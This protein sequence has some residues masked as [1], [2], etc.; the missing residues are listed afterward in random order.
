VQ[1]VSNPSLPGGCSFDAATFQGVFNEMSSTSGH[2]GQVQVCVRRAC[3]SAELKFDNAWY[4]REKANLGNYQHNSA[5]EPIV[6]YEGVGTY[7]GQTLDVVITAPTYPGCPMTK[8][9][10]D[11]YPPLPISFMGGEFGRIPYMH[12]D[13]VEVT[14]EFQDHTTHEPVE[15][16]EFDVTFFDLDADPYGKEQLFIDGF[17]RV[18]EES[19]PLYEVKEMGGGRLRVTGEA[20]YSGDKNPRTV[21]SLTRDQRQRSIAFRFE[22]TSTFKATMGVTGSPQSWARIFM[23]GF[24]SAMVTEPPCATYVAPPVPYVPIP[25]AF[26]ACYGS[27]PIKVECDEGTF[28]GGEAGGASHYTL[29]C[30]AQGSFMFSTTQQCAEVGFPVNGEIT[31]AQSASQ[32]LSGAK[33]SFKSVKTGAVMTATADAWGRYSADLGMG[34]WTATASLDGYIE[35]TKNIT[36]ATDISVGGAAD[37]GLSK[38]L[39]DGQWRVV[40]DWGAEPTDLDSHIYFGPGGSKH[41]Y[42]GNTQMYDP[43]SGLSVKLDRDD[44][45]SFGPETT[46]FEGT[47]HCDGSWDGGTGSSCLIVFK[48]HNYGGRYQ[49]TKMDKSEGVV[50]VYRG[51]SIAATYKIPECIGPDPLWYTVFTLDAREGQQKLYPGHYYLPPTLRWTPRQAPTYYSVVNVNPSVGPGIWSPMWMGLQGSELQDN[52]YGK[53]MTGM[54]WLGMQTGQSGFVQEVSMR[55]QPNNYFGTECTEEDLTADHLSCPAGTFISAIRRRSGAITGFGPD[56]W[57]EGNAPYDKIMCCKIKTMS[58]AASGWGKCEEV[59]WWSAI[60]ETTSSFCPGEHGLSYDGENGKKMMALVEL[61]NV[62]DGTTAGTT[63][64]KAKCCE[65]NEDGLVEYNGHG[66]VDFAHTYPSCPAD[67]NSR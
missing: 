42:Y 21:H 11:N 23:F 62:A 55:G 44:T 56:H 17:T 52:V 3:G 9:V 12:G 24:E 10:R 33:L 28:V 53:V 58:G 37:F 59:A 63:F 67:A 36:V 45:S 19:N 18:F 38:I 30:S 50:T 32:K 22:H 66:F 31:D 41:V 49:S 60:G 20:T 43:D 34:I 47:E 46:T 7:F 26:E 16:S 15:L 4:D 48:V 40:L 1:T 2:D 6:R 61:Q 14:F 35:M 8:E 51:S 13:S 54:K 64:T 5:L 25:S 57:H 29:Q 39:G 27:A 65:L